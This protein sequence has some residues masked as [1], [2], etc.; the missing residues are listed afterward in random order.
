MLVAAGNVYAYDFAGNAVAGQRER[1][2]GYWRDVGTLDAYYD[3]HR[4]LLTAEPAFDLHNDRWPI[5]SGTPGSPARIVA[6]GRAEESI[7]GPGAVIRGGSVRGS[8][9]GAGVTIED[10]AVVEDSVLLPG[11]RIGKG[12][13]VRRAVLDTKVDVADGVRLGVD[14][15]VDAELYPMST[16]GVVVLG[17][18]TRLDGL[19]RPLVRGAHPDPAV[20][21]RVRG[22]PAR[23]TGLVAATD[24]VDA[25]M[26]RCRLRSAS[27]RGGRSDPLLGYQSLPRP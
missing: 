2:R 13:V 27:R 23:R 11:V 15:A 22:I 25:A 21:R 3:A 5:R 8:V 26:I 9:V 6:G 10:G 24:P 19:L 18:A 12:A 17:K 1:E 4:D 20:R 7:V 16:N 14:H